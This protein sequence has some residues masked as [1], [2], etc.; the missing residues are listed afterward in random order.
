MN[1]FLLFRYG[2]Y[3]TPLT[4]S[5][6]RYFFVLAIMQNMQF[7]KIYLQFKSVSLFGK[8]IIKKK[9]YL[10]TIDNTMCSKNLPATF[11]YM[12][13]ARGFLYCRGW[14][15][16]C[17]YIQSSIFIKMRSFVLL[18]SAL[19]KSKWDSAEPNFSYMLLA[20]PQA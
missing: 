12:L 13:H 14:P 19:Y 10:E 9:S 20:G 5:D 8:K 6:C 11:R 3:C 2:Q 4:Q 16:K 18:S 17:N 7:Y 15:C 1:T